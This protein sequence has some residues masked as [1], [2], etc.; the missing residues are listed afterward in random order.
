MES[1]DGLEGEVKF[2]GELHQKEGVFYG[3]E[4]KENKG[5]NNGT[6]DDIY[7]FKTKDNKGKFVQQTQIKSIK[8]T[9]IMFYVLCMCLLLFNHWKHFCFI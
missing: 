5:T 7:Y 2:V 3:V 4:L 9:N 6:I 8:G 1:H